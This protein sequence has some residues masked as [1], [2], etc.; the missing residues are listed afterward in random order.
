MAV[1][2]PAGDSELPVCAACSQMST[3]SPFMQKMRRGG[4]AVDG[5]NYTNIVTKYDQL[6]RPYTSGIE[7]G[8]RNITVQDQ[9]RHDYT[10]HFEIAADPVAAATSSTRSTRPTRARS[11][12]WWSCPTRARAARDL[13]RLGR[14]GEVAQSVRAEDS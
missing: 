11:R 14:S 3:G 4:V 1:F 6:V 2:G 9:L 7:P 12:A 10:E 5:V 8:M 13:G